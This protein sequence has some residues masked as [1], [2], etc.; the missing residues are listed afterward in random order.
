M[1]DTPAPSRT[2]P[3]CPECGGKG[4]VWFCFC[5]DE[6]RLVNCP[7][8]FPDDAEAQRVAQAFRSGANTLVVNHNPWTGR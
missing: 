2:A 5:Q 1:S 7:R 4:K 8:C 3:K 6:S